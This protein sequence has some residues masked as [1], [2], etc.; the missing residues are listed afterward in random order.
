MQKS[1][2]A[3]RNQNQEEKFKDLDKVN[4][5][6]TESECKSLKELIP[7]KDLVIQKADK[8]CD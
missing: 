7:R 8:N 2:A 1:V 6:L 5:N 3:R 4:T